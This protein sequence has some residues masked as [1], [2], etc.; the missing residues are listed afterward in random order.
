M[1]RNF[2]IHLF[3]FGK[4]IRRSNLS[5]YHHSFIDVSWVGASSGTANAM[6]ISVP[7][8]KRPDSIQE[9]ADQNISGNEN[10]STAL[11]RLSETMRLLFLGSK[12]VPLGIRNMP[13]GPPIF[14]RGG[15]SP[16]SLMF[17]TPT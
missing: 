3:P 11:S 9:H 13:F 10:V 4:I 2:R 7:A 5:L 17:Q 14:H 6:Q 8:M 12:T 16:L 15:T 1:I